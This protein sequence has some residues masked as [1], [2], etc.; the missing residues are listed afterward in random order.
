MRKKEQIL[1]QFESIQ[2]HLLKKDIEN[3]E[4]L[5]QAIAVLTEVLVD[6]R[7]NLAIIVFNKNDKSEF[8]QKTPIPPDDVIRRIGEE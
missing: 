3:P 5:I 6:I 8:Q 4:A 1:D 2:R 7:S